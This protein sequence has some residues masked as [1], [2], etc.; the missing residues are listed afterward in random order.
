MA[1]IAEEE[2]QEAINIQTEEVKKVDAV[3]QSNVERAT[4]DLEETVATN[5]KAIANLQRKLMI[6]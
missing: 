6:P 4:A 2:K 3:R 5:A 1:P